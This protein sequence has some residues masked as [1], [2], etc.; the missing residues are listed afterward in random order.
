MFIA[1]EHDF[2]EHRCKQIPAGSR[3]ASRD[4]SGKSAQHCNQELE[5]VTS[6][7]LLSLLFPTAAAMEGD[8]ELLCL[9]ARY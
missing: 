8:R 6:N 2:V 3:A 7:S 9:T 1:S 5:F 4:V